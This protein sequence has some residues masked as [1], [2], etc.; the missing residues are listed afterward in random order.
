M[1]VKKLK[2]KIV[3]LKEK[4]LVLKIANGNLEKEI[5]RLNELY[6]ETLKRVR[7]K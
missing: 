3:Q 1:E 5:N 7:K 2:A 6:I 4:N